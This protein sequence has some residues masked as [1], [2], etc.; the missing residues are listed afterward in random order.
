MLATLQHEGTSSGALRER[1]VHR[2]IGDFALFWTGLFPEGLGRR[3][4]SV[5]PDRLIDYVERGKRSYAIVSGLCDEDSD[6][7]QSIFRR[8]SRDFEICAHGLG[9]VRRG[10]ER[11][12]PAGLGWQRELLY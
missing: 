11:E 7:P 10:W 5:N 2:H 12:D 6:P 4:V 9:L 3:R 8:L 1:E